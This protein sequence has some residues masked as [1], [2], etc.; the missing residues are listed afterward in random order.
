MI[1][2]NYTAKTLDGKVING[3]L[4]ASSE[5]EA[6]SLI[7]ELNAFPIKI[8]KEKAAKSEDGNAFVRLFIYPFWTGVN[9]KNLAAFYRQLSTLLA[10]GMSL[11]EGLN[12]IS[13][14]TKGRLGVIV[15]QAMDHVRNGGRFSEII[16]KHPRVFSYLQLSL[17]RAGESGGSMDKMISNIADY[18]DYEINI[19]R[20]ISKALFYP[21]IIFFFIIVS[22]A[23]PAL[24]M[25]GFDAFAKIVLARLMSWVP[26]TLIIYLLLRFL[27]QFQIARLVWDNIKMVPPVI[28]TA[29]RKIA[30]SRFAR[31]FSVLYNS[32]VQTSE[33]LSI[34][35]D[36]TGNIAIATNLKKAVPAIRS[37]RGLIE[38]LALTGAIMPMVMD[39]LAVG[40]KTGNFSVVLEKTCDHL[41]QEVD[42]TLHKVGIM[43]FV[44]SLIAAGIV[45]GFMVLSSYT[46]H[47]DDVLKTAE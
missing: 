35:A 6:V 17:I 13:S 5:S 30:M 32:G 47:F 15:V 28:G 10:A 14:R 9:L 41:D 2:Y 16:E 42:S 7:R 40:E 44:L 27:L 38:S 37:G 21:I 24:I 12:S 43:V 25:E 36:A 1:K 39:M 20:N 8:T 22:P 4:E 26:Q 29:A 11:S 33:A 18:L 19:R 31:A 45:V 34:A 23:L 46:T 3:N